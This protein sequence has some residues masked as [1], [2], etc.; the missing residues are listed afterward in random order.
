MFIL[1]FLATV[2]I[3]AR[4]FHIAELV[5]EWVVA[6][7]AFPHRAIASVSEVFDFVTVF[8]GHN[9]GREDE[10]SKGEKVRELHCGFGSVVFV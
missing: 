5:V 3:A 10:R 8:L 4:L 1:Q 9:G 2:R 6:V 7:L